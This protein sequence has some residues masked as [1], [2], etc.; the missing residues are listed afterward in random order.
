MCVLEDEEEE[1]PS[2]RGTVGRRG[3]EVLTLAVGSA[4]VAG[5]L[6]LGT[7]YSTGSSFG[8]GGSG[9]TVMKVCCSSTLAVSSESLAGSGMREPIVPPGLAGGLELAML[10]RP[11]TTEGVKCTLFLMGSSPALNPFVGGSGERTSDASPSRAVRGGAEGCSFGMILISRTSP[12]TS[13]PSS[14]SSPN[15]GLVGVPAPVPYDQLP[16]RLGKSPLVACVLPQESCRFVGSEEIRWWCEGW[17]GG[18]GEA[19]MVPV[20]DPASSSSSSL[21][22]STTYDDTTVPFAV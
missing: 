8:L 1:E 12:M 21:G 7:R 2:R 22:S 6:V 4:L 9:G 17:T 19:P 18:R 10:E 15:R 11:P 16:E 13:E 14:S 3:G 5:V 20:I